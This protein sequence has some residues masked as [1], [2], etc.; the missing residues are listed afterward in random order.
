[1]TRQRR[2]MQTAL[3]FLSLSILA[4]PYPMAQTVER[5]KCL[6]GGLVSGSALNSVLDSALAIPGMAAAEVAVVQDGRIAYDHAGGFLTAGG[7]VRVSPRTVFRAASLSKPVFAY[8]VL[9]LADEAVLDLDRPLYQY[10]SRPLSEY[11]NYADLAADPRCRALTARMALAHTTGF[12]NWRWQSRDRR[13]KILFDP[14]TRFSYSGE[15]YLYLQFVVESLTG[16]GL[17]EL[18]SEKVFIPLGMEQSSY[19]WLPRF[20]GRTALDLAG[21][22]QEFRDKIRTEANAAGSLFTTAT[23]YARFLQAAMEGKFLQQDTHAGM[24]RQQIAI[25]APRLFGARGPA[26]P[27]EV[28]H[29]SLAWA[30]GWGIIRS[31]IGTAYF[32]VGAEPGCENYAA[33]FVGQKTGYVLLSSGGE[34]NGVTRYIAPRLIGDGVSPFDRLGY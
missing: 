25:S 7:Q 15:G 23:D 10:L 24:L 20:E 29:G 30:L 6:D 19:L 13:L 11:P 4:P 14:G 9:R 21:L 12:P 3:L 31:A 26:I 22:P 5:I 18:A 1:M 28:R 8:L 2:L 34:F 17:D 32:H 27:E 33:Y 16:K